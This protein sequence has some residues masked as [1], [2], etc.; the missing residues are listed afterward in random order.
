MSAAQ[1]N[2][3]EEILKGGDI[4]PPLS[5]PKRNTTSSTS[6][7]THA[8]EASSSPEPSPPCV[9]RQQ[10]TE[11]NSLPEGIK[12]SYSSDFDLLE[13]LWNVGLGD[14]F[15]QGGIYV[16]RDGITVD[17]REEIRQESS[18]HGILKD[19][20][21]CIINQWVTRTGNSKNVVCKEE[22]RVAVSNKYVEGE[23]LD[24]A[25][26]N[27]SSFKVPHVAVYSR[28]RQREGKRQKSVPIQIENARRMFYMSPQLLIQIG[29]TNTYTKEK[30]NMDT[31]MNYAGMGD[32][33]DCQRPN[34]GYY[35]KLLHNNTR[36][37][38]YTAHGFLV[39]KVLQG[40]RMPSKDAAMNPNAPVLIE[41]QQF[42]VNAQGNFGED[43]IIRIDVNEALGMDV[44]G[45]D[46]YLDISLDELRRDLEIDCHTVFQHQ[47][48]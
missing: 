8:T 20:V 21:G 27:P 15:F 2:D 40:E 3:T 47:D 17:K 25:D 33:M 41:R 32:F 30:D 22:K 43:A 14:L 38:S 9:S 13:D 26:R 34:V 48:T 29:V 5:T 10:E 11:P 46:Q 44:T 39:I 24:A 18:E 19:T 28:D 16:G 6:S 12:S 31:L 4:I 42:L 7:Q 23:A 1:P 35:I 37:V 36:M 45:Q